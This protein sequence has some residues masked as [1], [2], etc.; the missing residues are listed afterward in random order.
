MADTVVDVHVVVGAEELLAGRIWSRRRRGSES[1]SFTYDNAYLAHPAAYALEPGLPLAAGQQQTPGERA[2]FAAFSDCA[3]DRWG[4]RLI[5][6]DE[7]HRAE[8]DGDA[9][10]SFGEIDYVLGVRDD[11]RQ[12]ALRFRDPDGGPYLAEEQ[13]GIP[14]LLDL[15][16]LLGA[17]DRLERDSATEDE[18]HLLLQGG[19]SLGGARP[20]VHVL[21]ADGRIAIAKFPSPSS[22]DWDVMRW[23]S[24]ALRLARDAGI[25]VP[26]FHLHD[27]GGTAVLIVDRF[28]RAGEQRVGYASAMTML[29]HSDGDHGSYLDIADVIET[30]SPRAG[31][32][33]RE[34][35]RRMVF[36]V[37][38]RNVDDHLRNHGFLRE[39]TAGWTLSPAFDLNPDPRPG[40]KLLNTAIDYDAREARIDLAL[41]VAGFFR[42]TEQEAAAVLAEVMGATRGWRRAATEAGLGSSEIDRMARAFEHEEAERARVV[43]SRAGH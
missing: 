40:P 28:D 27:V 36:S 21:D 37:L 10:R 19:S 1:A 23:E 42:L 26:D 4:R 8:R 2:T 22:D 11:L 39:T 25:R 41:D 38:I 14:H 15:G 12:G 20:K 34:L 33:L 16:A 43:A 6:R 35:W 3:P 29:E 32:D 30:E 13:R 17:A 18:L 9:E 5:Q 7:E 24:A 31:D